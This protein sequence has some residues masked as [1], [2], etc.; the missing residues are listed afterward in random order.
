[1]SYGKKR[2][3]MEERERV[4]EKLESEEMGYSWR[5]GENW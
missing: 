2:L 5:E 3:K 4:V 1:M